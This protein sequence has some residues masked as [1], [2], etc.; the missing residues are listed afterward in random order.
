[1]FTSEPGNIKVSCF[2]VDW[3]WFDLHLMLH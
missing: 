2:S 3:F 1:V